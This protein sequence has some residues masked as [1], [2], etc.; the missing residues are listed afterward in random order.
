MIPQAANDLLAISGEDLGVLGAGSAP[1]RE[2]VEEEDS[3]PV[4]KVVESVALDQSATDDVE[5]VQAGLASERE[6]MAVAPRASDERGVGRH[7]GGAPNRDF[8]L[9]VDARWSETASSGTT[10]ETSRR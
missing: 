2:A 4:A 10:S 1:E 5:G 6:E 9:A 3:C 7:P 8:L